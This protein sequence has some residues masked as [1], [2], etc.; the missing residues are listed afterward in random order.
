MCFCLVKL[1]WQ[2]ALLTLPPAFNKV[3][4][5]FLLLVSVTPVLQNVPCLTMCTLWALVA[6]LPLPTWSV[7]AG[8]RT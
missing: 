6:P 5:S 7:S 1:S 4:Y 2:L 8:A 3:A